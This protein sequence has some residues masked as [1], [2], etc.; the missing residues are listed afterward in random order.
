VTYGYDPQGRRIKKLV[1]EGANRT[2]THYVLD[3]ERAYHEIVIERTQTNNDPWQERAY[4]HT[5]GGVGELIS[6]SDGTSTRQVYTDGQGSTRLTT[7]GTTTHSWSFDAFGNLQAG[8]SAPVTH[9][10][11]G[12]RYDPD[13]G[14][15]Y[16]RARNYDPKT[17]RFISMD[18]HPG[19]Q[20]IPL[21]LNKYL[22][23]NADPV[24]HVDPSGYITMGGV[25]SGVS[26]MANIAAISIVRYQIFDMLSN[27]LL[28]PMIEA[29]VDAFMM[30]GQ[31]HSRAVYGNAG[32]AQLLTSLAVQCRVMK[33]C[34][35]RKVP[36]MVNGWASPQTTRHIWDSLN[37]NG[38]T[39]GDVPYPLSFILIKGPGRDDVR[40]GVR[41]SSIRCGNRPAGYD[42][43]EYPYASTFN[44]GDAMYEL[45]AVSLRAVPS[46]DNRI[47]GAKLKS[48]YTKNG[49]GTGEPFINLAI[50]YGPNFYIDKNGNAHLQ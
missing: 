46:G 21:T 14:L 38:G 2:E 4:L 1:T 10:Y 37:G 50:P 35:F 40:P 33:K 43:D 3:T 18:E 11:T 32:V 22:Y 49:I 48:F 25:M 47:Q 27:A 24:N 12:E 34:L 39:N 42:C 31:S 5:P 15:I 36:V 41:N 20:R 7:D 9:L 13:T 6:D 28:S 26:G 8:S 30:D 44:G 23:G 17:G 29:A 45:G 16:L 19:S